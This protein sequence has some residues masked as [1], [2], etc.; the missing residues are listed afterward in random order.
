MDAITRCTNTHTREKE[1]QE[2]EE[3]EATS[4][5]SLSMD[6]LLFRFYSFCSTPLQDSFLKYRTTTTNTEREAGAR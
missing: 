1:E 3:E 4:C 5:A 2:E 6:Q